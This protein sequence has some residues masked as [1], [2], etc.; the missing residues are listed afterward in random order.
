[1]ILR[2]N[3]RRNVMF[4]SIALIL[5]LALA[6]GVSSGS[7]GPDAANGSDAGNAGQEVQSV[8]ADGTSAGATDPDVRSDAVQSEPTATPELPQAQSTGRSGGSVGDQAPDFTGITNWINSEPLSIEDLRGKVVLVDVWTY[9]CINCIRTFPFLRDW[10]AKY[11]DHGLVIV[12]V[13][14]PEFEFEKETE[15]VIEAANRNELTWPIAQDNDFKT[16][17]AYNNRFWPSKYLL[18][19]DGVVRYTHFGEGAYGE[20]E[21]FIR[22]LLVEIGADLSD[23]LLELPAD[24]DQDATFTRM[25]NSDPRSAELTREL[26]AGYERNF[27]AI[28][29]GSEPYVVQSE[30]YQKRDALGSFEA[31]ED[32]VP[33]KVYFNGD[34]FVGPEGAKHGRMSDNYVD[35]VAINYSAKS[36]NVVITSDSGDP[37]QVRVTMDGEYLTEENR[38]ADVMIGEDGE[39]YLLVTEA[40]LYSVVNNPMYIKRSTLRL[41]PNSDDFER[42]RWTRW[43]RCP[44]RWRRPAATTGETATHSQSAPIPHWIPRLL[45]F[46]DI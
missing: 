23:D 25:L 12:G 9:T 17:R 46:P 41:S 21:Q 39:S 45:P 30:Y 27:S 6:C 32:L 26:Y 37:Y 40:K 31:P 16:W 24:Q 4:W 34:W 18:D 10:H 38:G 22:Q 11:A 5:I 20:T 29:R 7:L 44:I 36:V 19:R 13:H 14:S 1:M 28:M 8:A 3:A 42:P 15:N 35:Y 33:H 2:R 43:P